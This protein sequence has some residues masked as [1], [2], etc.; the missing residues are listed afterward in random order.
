MLQ[1]RSS[2]Q[3]NP[4]GV[5]GQNTLLR[6]SSGNRTIFKAAEKNPEHHGMGATLTRR[7]S[8]AQNSASLT[9]V[10][11]R[12]YLLRSGSLLQLTRDHSLVAE[13]VRRGILT[14]PR[15]KKAT[16]KAFCCARL[17]HKRQS[18]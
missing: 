9:S 7:G 5:P 14:A 1:P 11:A 16:C 15:P 13:Q 6:P 18:K 17:A 4:I 10:T 3:Y 12:A 8:M 2:A